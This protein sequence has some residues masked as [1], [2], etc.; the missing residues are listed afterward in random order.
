MKCPECRANLEKKDREYFFCEYCGC[1]IV[2][3]DEKQEIN[4]NKNIN[5]TKS[6][7]H[8]R[9]YINEA[10]V[11]KARAKAKERKGNNIFTIVFLTFLVFGIFAF[12]M[13]LDADLKES[14]KRSIEQEAQ[15]EALVNEIMQDIEYEDFDAAYVK[16]NS[17]YYTENWSS[18]IEDKWDN[19]RKA[20]LK[21][22][23]E[24][25]K[26]RKRDDKNL[27]WNFFD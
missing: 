16:A 21:E 11:I 17:L 12:F 8:I 23:E 7:S 25:E 5:S 6:S 13:T 27:F 15:L 22:I 4:I 9:H 18:E 10:E 14:E 3:D 2:L 19:T 20:I 1:K 26:E 24:A